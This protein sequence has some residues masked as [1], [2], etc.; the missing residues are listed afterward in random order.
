M[1]ETSLE[2]LQK[3]FSAARSGRTVTAQA[4]DSEAVQM[5]RNRRINQTK[6]A[7]SS[8]VTI[9]PG[10]P[11]DP[12]FYWAN[13]NL[14]YDISKEDQM[15]QVRDF[16]RILYLTHPVIG[17]AIDIYT[18]YPLAGMEIVCP[19]DA[20][21]AEF[22]T[23][24][25]L[26]QLNYEEFLAD[27]GREYWIAGE[28]FPMGSFN[29]LLGVWEADELLMP[30]DVNV[31]RSPF[32]REP[33]FEMAL[34]KAI[35]D[36]IINRKPELEYRQIVESY[37]E[38]LG[39][40]QSAGLHGDDRFDIPVS[41]MLLQHVKRTGDSFHPRGVP[42]LLRAF[43]S[44][45]QEEMLMAA[46]D[47][48]AQRLYTPLILAKI[49][50]SASDLG[51]DAPWIPSTGDIDN[52]LEDV[53]VAL[54][55][56]FRVIAHHFAVDISNVF[57]RES[58]PDMSQDFE[59]LTE[60]S[61]QAF[62]MSKTMV[63]GASSG[64]TYAADA[65]NRDLVSQMLTAFQRK[66]KRFARRRFEVVA[67]AQGHYDFERKGGQVRPIMEEVLEKDDE[68]GEQRVI[69]RPKL[70]VPELRIKSMNLKDDEKMRDFVEQLRASGVPVSMRT[71][72]TNIP[73]VLEDEVQG[74]IDEQVEQAVAAQRARRQTYLA[75]KQDGLP[76][77]EDLRADF[78][79]HVM[80]N[81]ADPLAAAATGAPGE[82]KPPDEEGESQAI[83]TL[84][85]VDPASTS[86][87]AP[88]PDDIAAL[89]G[90]DAEENGDA[91]IVVALP[92]N[93]ALSDMEGA[94]TPEESHEQRADMP[95]AAS[96]E[97][98]ALEWI[99]EDKEPMIGG[100]R[101]RH[102]GHRSRKAFYRA[103]EVAPD[104]ADVDL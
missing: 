73:I 8:S 51:T 74:V 77:S 27:L 75:L 56:D 2:D 76:I 96:L 90:L 13:R 104:K 88:T 42:I 30:E 14:P 36:I 18:H 58:I 5:E 68:T 25:F 54:M 48:I 101:L 6:T 60:R 78:E 1:A 71:R 80:S 37:P 64:E 85:L 93:R 41:P 65:M 67:E 39:Y 52:F 4:G 98:R 79:P 28:A 57:G 22:Y 61:L 49:G 55:A 40:A 21:I 47:S 38:L 33:R 72:L 35:R 99:G 12:M 31:I 9:S 81:G 32:L 46:M 59:R 17:S 34:P 86:A 69:S 3:L 53:N 102:V 43:R 103:N 89:E 66:V 23:D 45:V 70:L 26:D 50:A 84:G 87:L 7:G 94:R 95:K 83:P 97:E 91:P 20:K 11:T 15:K 19:K 82:E 16:S 92:Q 62:G 29:E 63:S 100:Y 10:R 44:A 24:L